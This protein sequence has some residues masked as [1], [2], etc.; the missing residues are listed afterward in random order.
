MQGYRADI[1]F[2]GDRE[3]PGGALVL[4]DD[5]LI[6]GVE[7]GS[8]AAPAG[9]EVTHVAGT[10]L[11]PGLID[12]HTH[13][14]GDDTMQALDQLPE[15]GADELDAIVTA[16]MR[17]QLAAGVTAVRDLGDH[18]WTVVDRHRGR[19]D[20][21]TVVASGPPITSVGGH[22]ANMGGAAAGVDQ[23]RAAVRERAERG[24]DVVKIMTSGGMM[25]AGTDILVPQFTL[26]E[27]SAVVEEAHRLGLAVAAHA[28]ALAAVEQCVQARVDTI[29]HC[30]CMTEQGLFTPPALA[31]AM[32]AA[33]VVACPTLGQDLST[34]DGEL[35]PNIAAAMERIGI[36]PETRARQ[37]AGLY[38]GGVT[39]VSGADSGIN[40]S[41]PHGLL[42]ESI[43]D[44]VTSCGVP[45]AE[46]LASATGIAADV[47]GLGQR[48]GRLH[49]GLDADLLLVEGDV[50]RD[51]TA[52]GRPHTVVS[53][54]RATTLA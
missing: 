15:L 13:L 31:T 5:G 41:K 27:L 43:V 1:A 9:C 23:L 52:V 19:P 26:V 35:P 37:V 44:L 33:G 10:T 54:G 46:G 7:P 17:K 16:S 28:H 34:L 40:P 29:E 49:K 45:P 2:D 32:A 20:G 39:L 24:A 8:A 47:C 11:L 25:T 12:A 14:C 6:I 51:I 36:T 4:V 50:L 53:R 38:A 21:L 22:C 42:P 48:T 30:S 3:L 18:R